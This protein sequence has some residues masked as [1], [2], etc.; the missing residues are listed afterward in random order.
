M[1]FITP[2]CQFLD[3]AI[4]LKSF[5]V[6]LFYEFVRKKNYKKNGGVLNYG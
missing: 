3:P 2:C 5:E 6:K 1:T 4:F